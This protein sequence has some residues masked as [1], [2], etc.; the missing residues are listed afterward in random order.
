MTDLATE[1]ESLADSTAGP[2]LLNSH[3]MPLPATFSFNYYGMPFDV[4][5]RR[6]AEGGAE[7]VVRGKLGN[8]PFSAESVPARDLLRSVVD[9]GRYL[10]MVD[11]DIDRRQAIIARGTMTFEAVPSPATVAAGTAAIAMAVKPVC[12]LIVKSNDLPQQ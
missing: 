6:R 1:I 5:V 4:G 12:E 8:L 7:L 9:A 11:V 2:S 3:R 10:P